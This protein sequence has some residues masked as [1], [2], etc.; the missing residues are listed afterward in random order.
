MAK[1]NTPSE[2]THNRETWCIALHLG[3]DQFL[4]AMVRTWAEGAY[5]SADTEPMVAEGVIERER[6]ATVL[7]ANHLEKQVEG[8]A[9][10][11]LSAATGDGPAIPSL[12]AN[13][14]HDVG[15]LYRVE[16]RDVARPYVTDLHTA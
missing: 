7:L 9:E 1:A 10:D 15:S 4:D 16:W 3:N 6:M 12:I 14:L 5:E 8:W 11:M 2:F 13:M